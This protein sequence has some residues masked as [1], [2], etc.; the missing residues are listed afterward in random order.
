MR[1]L[2]LIGKK[3]VERETT[4]TSRHGVPVT[5]ETANC[6]GTPV[7][8]LYV[9]RSLCATDRASAGSTLPNVPVAFEL[10]TMIFPVPSTR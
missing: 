3:R 5:G 6:V 9:P 10:P 1:L 8:G 4:S 2:A 7:L